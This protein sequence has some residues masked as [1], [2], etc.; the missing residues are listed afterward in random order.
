MQD[1]GA[2]GRLLIFVGAVIILVGGILIW[3]GRSP[4]PGGLGRLPGDILIERKNFSVYF[5]ITTG[6]ILSVILSLILWL[7]TRR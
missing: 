4:G 5:P 2:I 1:L 3:I 6:L 7:L